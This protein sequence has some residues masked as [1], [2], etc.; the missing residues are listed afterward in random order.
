MP[1]LGDRSLLS[2]NLIARLIHQRTARF[3]GL[4]SRSS[5][6][7][8]AASLM[9]YRVPQRSAAAQAGLTPVLDAQDSSQIESSGKKIAQAV[10]FPTSRT[11]CGSICE[12][13]DGSVRFCGE[14]PLE[15][16][17]VRRAFPAKPL[18]LPTIALAGF[19]KA[20]R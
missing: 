15:F 18:R 12:L 9:R 10:T 17:Q 19:L 13:G 7:R 11:S 1:P 20:S 3:S 6:A 5:R 2:L 8:F 4:T 16:K 14:R